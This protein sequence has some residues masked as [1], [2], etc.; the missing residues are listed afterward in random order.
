MAS[1]GTSNPA[2]DVFKGFPPGGV[3]FITAASTSQSGG[4][5]TKSWL[6]QFGIEDAEWIPVYADNCA[7]RT[8]DPQYV[9]MVE[10]ADAIFIGG[11]QSGRVS[12]C[13]FGN[14]SASGIDG[15]VETPLLRAIKAKAIVGGSSAGAMTQP[16]SEILVTA[17][18]VES[19]SAVSNGNVF[20]RD[21]GNNL[22]GSPHAVDTHFSER[23]RQG[24]LVVFAMQT[25]AEWAFGVDEGTTY[26]WSPSGDCEVQGP[27]GVVI[28]Q[29][30]QG[31]PQ[32]QTT[33]MHF[34]TGGDTININTGEIT[35]NPDKTVCATGGVP[36]GSNSIFNYGASTYRTVSIAAAQA[37]VGTKV[38]N[39][40]GSPA[41]QVD[42]TK[43]AATV[44]MCGP[45]GQSFANLLVEQ[46]QSATVAFVNT[47][48]PNIAQDYIWP[49]D[50]E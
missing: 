16:T 45:S 5:S 38:R 7:S 36:S 43:Q 26:L 42:F 15:G 3:K 29:G 9:R 12:S 25:N 32:S 22:L 35:Y 34:L 6:A 21:S 1:G 41:V 14:Y 49:E 40:H 27:N 2:M 50:E 11:G 33:T 24:R 37:P 39:F 30:T 10:E 13:L 46:F 20:Q 17:Y 19:Y 4:S 18:S 8:Q 23:G 47:E 28:Y 31:T 44:A 48:K